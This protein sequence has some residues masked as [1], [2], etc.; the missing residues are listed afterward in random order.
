M[1]Q[2][3]YSTTE[4]QLHLSLSYCRLLVYSKMSDAYQSYIEALSIVVEPSPFKEATNS[5]LWIDAM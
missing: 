4:N 3:L 2:G 1:A 5:Q